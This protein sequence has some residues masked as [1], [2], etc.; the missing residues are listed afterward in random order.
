MSLYNIK[1]QKATS[2]EYAA[3][4]K[5]SLEKAYD[6]VRTITGTQHLLQKRLYNRHVHGEPHQVG[7]HVWM[8]TT[9]LACGNTKKLHHPWTGSYCVV[10]R[11]SDSTYRIQL[12]SSP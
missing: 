9:V 10:K 2:S 7:D 4:L 6:K 3:D 5:Q 1:T 12:L 11:I 8:H